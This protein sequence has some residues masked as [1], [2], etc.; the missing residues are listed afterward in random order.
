MKLDIY[1][2][3]R[4]LHIAFIAGSIA[5]LLAVAAAPLLVSRGVALTQS[6]VIEEDVAEVLAIIL[7]M[8]LSAAS[9]RIYR[10]QL[11]RLIREMQDSTRLC[12]RLETRLADAFGYIG[13]VN[14]EIKEIESSLCQL[15]RYPA[16]RKE[17]QGLLRDLAQRAMVIAGSEWAIVRVMDR[18]N[19]RTLREAVQQR[20]GSPRPAIAISN[21]SLVENPGVEGFSVV[22][23]GAENLPL[24]TALVFPVKRLQTQDRILV[25][26]IAG[27]IEMLFLIFQ[28]EAVTGFQRAMEAKPLETVRNQT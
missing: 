12:R 7:L 17:F 16:S 6:V 18:R 8:G 13:T 23:T 14:V 11:Q 3:L 19:F 26:A 4:A 21:R 28:S 9:W 2:R 24:R 5:L 25:S 15:R 22:K 10:R 20:A 27:E 1:T